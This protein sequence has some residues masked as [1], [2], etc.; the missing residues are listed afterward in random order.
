M[1]PLACIA[2]EGC[3]LPG[4]G[5]PRFLAAA[6]DHF[7]D[8][9]E[10]PKVDLLQNRMVELYE[11]VDATREAK[12]LRYGH[13]RC[14]DDEVVVSVRGIFHAEPNHPLLEDFEHALRIATRLY[15]KGV[16]RIEATI[17]YRDLVAKRSFSKARAERAI[18]LLETESLVAPA[19]AG[20]PTMVILPRMRRFLRVRGVEEYVER[21]KRL[22]RRRRLKRL[23]GKPLAPLRWLS[24]EGKSI[25]AKIAVGVLALVAGS[26]LLAGIVWGVRQ[27]AESASGPAPTPAPRAGQPPRAPAGRR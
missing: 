9:G 22:D 5:N 2:T 19:P 27:L 15:R 10:W 12:R 24:R 20:A 13:G 26:I 11:P 16:S 23:A 3:H 18:K 21:Q 14:R 8:T 25:G 4:S 7:A 1:I 6:V 17:S